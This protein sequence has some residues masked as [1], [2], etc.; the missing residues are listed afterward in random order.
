MKSQYLQYL[1][2]QVDHRLTVLPIMWM[3]MSKKVMFPEWSE[4]GMIHH[5]VERSNSF[6]MF[7]KLLKHGGEN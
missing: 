2:C 6:R 1:S 3:A 4:I 5:F 7:L